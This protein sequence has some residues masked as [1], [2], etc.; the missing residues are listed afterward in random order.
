MC[1]VQMFLQF[2]LLH[3]LLLRLRSSTCD[4]SCFYAIRSGSLW[5]LFLGL[6][7]PCLS[8]PVFTSYSFFSFS[9]RSC[10]S[11]SLFVQA[12]FFF[13]S[14]PLAPS[15]KASPVNPA[16]PVFSS[17]EPAH[18][19][20]SLLFPLLL[21]VILLFPLLF[22]VLLLLILLLQVPLLLLLL[23]PLPHPLLRTRKSAPH[24]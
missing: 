8:T 16:P 6:V 1:L 12:L 21:Q 3:V 20:L 11:C 22:Q 15:E 2:S 23:L 10:S 17:L 9:S 19:G 4:S 18:Q 5:P 13:S 14:S 7:C 24:P